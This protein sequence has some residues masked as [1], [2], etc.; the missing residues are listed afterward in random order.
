MIEVAIVGGGPAG[1]YCAYCLAENGIHPTI[2]DH[3]HPR[4]KP[5]G[6]MISPLA[7]ELFPFLKNLPIDHIKRVKMYL[8]PPSGRKV[9]VKTKKSQIIC[10]SRL[11][12]D[13]FML[14]KAL[15]KG[16]ELAKE[17]VVDVERK[18]DLWKIKTDKGCYYAK[19][20]VGADGVNSIIRRR[21]M[22][23]LN[24]E[25]KGICYG[26]FVKGLENEDIHIY[27]LAHRTGYIWVIPRKE[28]TSIGIGCTEKMNLKGF[29]KELED[30]I[31]KRYPNA[32]KL[33]R[34][35]ALIP[36]IKSV[37][38]FSTP[39]CGKN[40]LLIGDAA[41]HVNPI[42]GEGIPYAMLDGELAAHAISQNNLLSF[43]LLWKRAYGL[44]LLMDIKLRKYIYNKQILEFYCEYLK[45]CAILYY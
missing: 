45:T 4:E 9:T 32:K 33:E 17:K 5:C 12:F 10:V 23:S 20:L 1:S 19:I 36:N 14:N 21:I 15:N 16:V 39:I 25:D 37:K 6:G 27:F 24:L 11:K 38:T 29:K 30:F 2:F 7:Q 44:N 42:L 22:K 40:W 31:A 8:F 34:W 3:S 18:N 26:Y 35:I 28:N 41:G 13:Q 43:D